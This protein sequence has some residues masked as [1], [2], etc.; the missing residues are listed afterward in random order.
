MA[1]LAGDRAQEPSSKTALLEA[2]TRLLLKEGYGAVS[3]RRVAGEAGVAL[4]LVHYYFGQ[5]EN[6]LLEVFRRRAEWMLEL[7]VTA[8][9]GDQPLWA[10]WDVTR[11]YADTPLNQEFLALG[12]HY[13]AIR[14]EVCAYSIRFRRLQDELVSKSLVDRQV[15]TAMWPPEGVLLLIDGMSRFLGSEAAYGMSFGHLQAS[16]IIERM[17]ADLEGPRK[18]P[19]WRP[20][21]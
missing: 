3:A 9:A 8:L 16:M 12:N 19:R 13:T 17:I 11:E 6:L 2:A 18:R 21:A 5:M 4:G 1:D 15:D 7:E 14:D 20:P 10:L